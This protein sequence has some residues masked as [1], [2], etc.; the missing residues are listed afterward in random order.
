M[1]LFSFSLAG[2]IVALVVM[3]ASFVWLHRRGKFQRSSMTE[4]EAIDFVQGRVADNRHGTVVTQGFRGRA[5]GMGMS[6][7]IETREVLEM[8]R[9]GRYADAGPWLGGI[10]GALSAFLFWPMW[11]MELCGADFAM[12]LLVTGISFV[13]ALRAAWPRP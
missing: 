6:A 3:T 13:T 2:S 9:Q 1:T 11:I 12:N 4:A 8:V 10:L 5:W 7:E